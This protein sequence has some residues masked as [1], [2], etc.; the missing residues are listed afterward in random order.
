M[1]DLSRVPVDEL[2][3]QVEHGLWPW[4]KENSDALA[5]LARRAHRYEKAL[6]ELDALEWTEEVDMN[7][8]YTTRKPRRDME[9]V[10]QKI[11]RAALDGGEES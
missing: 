11:L 6:S 7:G 5:E 2:A 8:E 1:S 10:V 9:W 4:D 3:E